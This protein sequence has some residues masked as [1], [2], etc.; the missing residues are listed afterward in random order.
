MQL[1]AQVERD[2][3][4]LESSSHAGKQCLLSIP[5][6]PFHL[7]GEL[8]AMVFDACCGDAECGCGGAFRVSENEGETRIA[9]CGPDCVGFDIGVRYAD[10][11]AT[12]QEKRYEK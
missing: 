6:L 1:E 9:Y 8:L 7:S 12:E 3:L 4:C 2:T 10:I 5:G 11:D